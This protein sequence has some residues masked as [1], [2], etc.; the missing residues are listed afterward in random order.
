MRERL[1]MMGVDCQYLFHQMCNKW[2]T[3]MR[4]LMFPSP[5]DVGENVEG[6]P[7][8]KMPIVVPSRF[9]AR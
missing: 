2:V 4:I 1:N 9:P 5:T 7:D 8:L 3:S 6:H